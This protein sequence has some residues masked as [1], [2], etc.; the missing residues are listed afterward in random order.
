MTRIA[1]CSD[2]HLWFDATQRF[3]DNGEQ[4]QPW[5]A[6]ILAT[7]LAEVQAA[8]PAAI[9]HLGDI[10]CGGGMFNMPDEQFY[11]S[12]AQ[13]VRA[14]QNASGG[15]LYGLPGNHDCPPGGN[16]VYAE[17]LLGLATGLGHTLDLP[18]ARLILLN[19]QGHSPEQIAVALPLDPVYGW[20]NEAELARLEQALATAGTRPVVIFC[21]QLLRVWVAE[22]E[23]R[24]FYWLR[25]ADVVLALLARYE[26]VRAV[27]QG[28]AHRL[29]VQFAQ[30]D[31]NSSQAA[32]CF[33]VLP[34]LIE[35]PL[36]WLQLDFSAEQLQV[37]HKR[38]PLAHLA[39]MSLEQGE[40]RSW[41]S[42]R[43]EWQSFTIQLT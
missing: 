32:C 30:L 29:D 35:Y 28:H 18:E 34:A 36:G 31:P 23:W 10:S 2:T 19:A 4:L 8:V 11:A 17:Q 12:L 37:T 21:H 6:E 39:A 3:G 1:L 25:N 33:V 13:G 7:L 26:N 27:F 42:G 24:D 20:V 5:C 38:L 40:D 9:L 41:R 14:F 22:Y 15:N 43:P 16:Y